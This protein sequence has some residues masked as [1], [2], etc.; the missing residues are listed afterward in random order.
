[1]G[2]PSLPNSSNLPASP[3]P[4][5]CSTSDVAKLIA[6][7]LANYGERKGADM[8]LVTAEWHAS[9]FCYPADRLSAALSEHIRRSTF[10]PTV[11]NLLDILREQA[12]AFGRSIA[13]FG[14]Y[15]FARDGRTEAEEIIHRAAQCRKWREDARVNLKPTD[16]REE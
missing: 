5:R 8:R 11:A 3:V 16:G 6:R 15:E 10:W 2:L 13:T 12:P 14:P 1:M 4:T 7:C 9:L